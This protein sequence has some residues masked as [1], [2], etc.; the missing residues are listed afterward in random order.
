[1]GGGITNAVGAVVGKTVAQQQQEAATKALQARLT[2]M[3]QKN[4]TFSTGQN[5][6]LNQAQAAAQQRMASRQI[7]QPYN[8]AAPYNFAQNRSYTNPTRNLQKLPTGFDK[9]D[10]VAPPTSGRPIPPS[11]VTP[12]PPDYGDIR[13]PEYDQYFNYGGPGGGGGGGRGPGSDSRGPGGPDASRP[14]PL[15]FPTAPPTSV[16]PPVNPNT[17]PD[18][19]APMPIQPPPVAPPT[20]VTPAVLPTAPVVPTPTPTPTP[21]PTPAPLPIPGIGGEGKNSGDDMRGGGGDEGNGSG[22]GL[23]ISQP[24]PAPTSVEPVKTQQGAPVVTTG[25]VDRNGNVIG[26]IPSVD[27]FGNAIEGTP[28]T[29]APAEF[30]EIPTLN[31]NARA[32]KMYD[33]G[34]RFENRQF[35][36]RQYLMAMMAEGGLAS[37]NHLSPEILQ[38]AGM[39]SQGINPYQ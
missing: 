3:L 25:S 39:L 18:L 28:A 1:M 21:V 35:N 22:A 2:A 20:Y 27:R 5:S 16:N 38:K 36:D 33:L 7:P 8:T 29:A 34:N 12:S 37:S 4:Q 11:I 6:M 13:I 30:D 15:V 31:P 14:S 24:T 23:P 10:V 9:K 32:R 17:I 26:N 19:V